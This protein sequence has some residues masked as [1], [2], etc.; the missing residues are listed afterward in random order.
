MEKGKKYIVTREMPGCSIGDI[1]EVGQLGVLTNVNEKIAMAMSVSW[2]R[3]ALSEGYVKLHV[4]PTVKTWYIRS[5]GEIVGPNMINVN[6]PL[7]HKNQ[8]RKNFGNLYY[9]REEAERARMTTA[10]LLDILSRTSS[11]RSVK[12]VERR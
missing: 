8:M 12:V 5:T 1:L 3:C 10:S 11:T 7:G 4:P 2:M 9:S 6:V